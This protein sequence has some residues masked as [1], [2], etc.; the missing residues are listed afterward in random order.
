MCGEEAYK[1]LKFMPGTRDASL[2]SQTLQDTRYLWTGGCCKSSC[3]GW[4][5]SGVG[6][7]LPVLPP[8]GSEPKQDWRGE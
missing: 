1:F 3:P 4:T 6:G 5:G 7:A 2:G 8:S